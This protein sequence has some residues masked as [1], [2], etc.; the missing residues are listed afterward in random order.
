MEKSAPHT[1]SCYFWNLSPVAITLLFELPSQQLILMS[2]ICFSHVSFHLAVG[3][4][5]NRRRLIPRERDKRDCSSEG[6]SPL[7]FF[8]LAHVYLFLLTSRISNAYAVSGGER[9]YQAEAIR[10]PSSRFNSRPVIPQFELQHSLQAQKPQ[11]KPLQALV[12]RHLLRKMTA[13][14]IY[15][16]NPRMPDCLFHN[17]IDGFPFTPGSITAL[18]WCPCLY[19][20]LL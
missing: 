12:E 9:D 6:L 15:L 11:R 17:A 3:C 2:S 1:A 16:P 18:F 13:T 20:V 14:F 4:T 5:S 7:F 8:I 19:P 10:L